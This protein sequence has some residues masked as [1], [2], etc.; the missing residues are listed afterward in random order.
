MKQNS[1][2]VVSEVTKP[3][4]IGLD[5]FD[6]TVESF[7]TGV[8]DSVLVKVE[9]SLLVAP[10]HLDHLFLTGSNLLLIALYD[11]ALKNRLAAPL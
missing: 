5:E 3:A 10:E 9:Q 4:G 6:G 11:Q 7:C 8:I 1:C 2:P